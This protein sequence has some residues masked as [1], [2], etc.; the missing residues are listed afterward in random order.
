MVFQWLAAW[1][2]IVILGT[3]RIKP[4]NFNGR[5]HGGIRK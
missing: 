3:Q 2:A 1:Q 5:T 4:N